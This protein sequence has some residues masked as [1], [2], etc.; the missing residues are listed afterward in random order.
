MALLGAATAVFADIYGT[1]P[2]G[3]RAD[4]EEIWDLEMLADLLLHVEQES[5]QMR[6]HLDLLY[7]VINHM[8]PKGRPYKGCWWGEH[9][10]YACP[11]PYHYCAPGGHGPCVEPGYPPQICVSPSGPCYREE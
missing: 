3:S 6:N 1:K 9:G 4:R 11:Y 2:E 5:A 8:K 10:G 7:G